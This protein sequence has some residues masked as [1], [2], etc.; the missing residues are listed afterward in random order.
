VNSF[1]QLQDFAVLI[2]HVRTDPL[3]RVQF[4]V[5]LTFEMLPLTTQLRKRKGRTG[6][7]ASL[8]PA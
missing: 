2:S 4:I 7:E 8:P 3:E 1:P 5:L 6:A